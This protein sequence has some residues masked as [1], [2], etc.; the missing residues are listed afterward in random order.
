V[1]PEDSF[2][3]VPPKPD[4]SKNVALKDLQDAP[5]GTEY[6]IV[7]EHGEILEY[8]KVGNTQG[9]YWA[10]N[11]ATA[12]SDDDWIPSEKLTVSEANANGGWMSEIVKKPKSLDEKKADKDI[13]SAEDMLESDLLGDLNDMKKDSADQSFKVGNVDVTPSD[14]DAAL[15]AIA[16]AKKG[17]NTKAVLKAADNPLGELDDWTA[18]A[19]AAKPGYAPKPGFIK[20]LQDLQK[21]APAKSEK[22]SDSGW[23]KAGE[24]KSV[25]LDVKKPLDPK[26]GVPAV[27][28]SSYVKPKTASGYAEGAYEVEGAF[29]KYKIQVYKDGSSTWVAT[30]GL[31]FH[32]NSGET[33]T[34]LDEH[35]QNGKLQTAFGT[36]EPSEYV[37]AQPA[38]SGNVVVPKSLMDLHSKVYA[39]A[40]DSGDLEA[41]D[42]V[43]DIL[44]DVSKGHL[45]ADAAEAKF[46]ALLEKD[47]Q[48]QVEKPIEVKGVTFSPEA[49]L[50]LKQG[51]ENG[52]DIFDPAIWE[53]SGVD[54][55]VELLETDDFNLQTVYDDLIEQLAAHEKAKQ[56][57]IPQSN[58]PAPP[59][60][61]MKDF[62][63]TPPG[64]Y[65]SNADLVN[66]MKVMAADAGHG[67]AAAQYRGKM[68][69]Q[70]KASWI[71]HWY[72][73][74]LD[75]AYAIE[76][77]AAKLSGK[78]GHMF[79]DKH[80][81][82]PQ[83]FKGKIQYA[84]AVP[85]EIPAGQEI[86][87]DSIPSQ[88]DLKQTSAWNLS[89]E[90]VDAY[91]VAA[92]MQYAHGL[93]EYDKRGWVMNHALGLK[94]QVDMA[95]MKAKKN[96]ASG[97]Y[98]SQPIVPPKPAL[99]AGTP[100]PGNFPELNAKLNH[101]VQMSPEQLNEYLSQVVGHLNVKAVLFQDEKTK[102]ALVQLHWLTTAPEGKDNFLSKSEATQKW[103]ALLKTLTINVAQYQSDAGDNPLGLPDFGDKIKDFKK[104]KSQKKLAGYGEKFFVEDEYGEKFLFKVAKEEFR[105]YTEDAAHQAASLF[106][107]TPAHSQVTKV[108]GQLGQIQSLIDHTAEIRDIKPKDLTDAQLADMLRE[109]VLDW[110]LDND[111]GHDQNFLVTPTGRVVGIDKGRAWVH[112]G[113]NKLDRHHLSGNAHLYYTDIYNAIASG[114]I[115]PERVTKAYQ[116]AMQR[117]RLMSRADDEKY[118][119]I[120]EYAFDK[121]PGYGTTTAANKAEL[122]DQVIARKNNLEQDF[123]EFW[124]KLFKDAGIVK[125]PPSKTIGE[126]VHV[127]FTPELMEQVAKAGQ[128]GHATFFAGKDLED[129]HVLVWEENKNGGKQ[130]NGQMQLTGQADAKLLSW[131]KTH[132][133]GSG[134][135]PMAGPVGDAVLAPA[136]GSPS[137]AELHEFVLHGIK[138]ISTHSMDGAYNESKIKN[139]E[140]AQGQIEVALQQHA[141]KPDQGE[142]WFPGKPKKAAAYVEMLENYKKSIDAALLAKESSSKPMKFQR[143][144]YTPEA[145]N[146]PDIPAIK[147]PDVPF[148]V[149][150]RDSQYKVSTVDEDTGQL[151]ATDQVHK[152]NSY[153]QFGKEYHVQ[154][155][156]GTEFSYRPWNKSNYQN[157]KTQQGQ[158]KFTVPETHSNQ[159]EALDQ[160]KYHLQSSGVS[161][162]EPAEE[163]LELTY[164]RHL[165]GIMNGRMD[166]NDGPQ[167][168]VQ[169]VVGDLGLLNGS[170]DR[171]AEI[172]GWRKAWAEHSGQS[173]V[174]SWVESKSFLPQFGRVSI[175][176]HENVHGRPYWN[177]F[178]VDY[179]AL[180]ENDL[181]MINIS[182]NGAYQLDG[183]NDSRTA[184]VAKSGALMS[185]DERIHTLGQY[186]GG[187]SSDA[188]TKKGSANYVFLRQNKSHAGV[189]I[190][191]DPKL[192]ARTSTYSLNSD[193]CGDVDLRS[194]MSP[195]DLKKASKFSAE[196]NE[197][198][199]KYGISILDDV[200]LM[201]FTSPEER[202]KI[203]QHYHD[204]GIFTLHGVPIEQVFVLK[205]SRAAGMAAA[206]ERVKNG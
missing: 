114:Q 158:L 98:N 171:D 189:N 23:L 97:Y 162:D 181:L 163:D 70:Q 200:Q 170:L 8:K 102:Q 184:Q 29:Q 43:D 11:G 14:I 160:I 10:P 31:D 167:A 150:L 119:K 194:T 79:A 128:H 183:M 201:V 107:F 173:K 4:A 117:A 103:D 188:D 93:T 164:W 15:E 76:D 147:M 115:E 13:P 133:D 48:E 99:P 127:G 52:A 186:V 193:N 41:A 89:T 21:K 132:A 80:P 17:Q 88:E 101:A 203:I 151:T 7:T 27:T 185:T 63:P 156:D 157:E 71:Q 105:P 139:L 50:K 56:I 125:P 95:S 100:V 129:G 134:G 154:F 120:L 72:N 28:P 92:G 51:A 86:I 57:Q 141:S 96:V 77:Y 75:K 190:Y 155:D 205:S 60:E 78:T 20:M 61:G 64:S 182:G 179:K 24:A 174:D 42:D 84:A 108:D 153:L 138:T 121:R 65:S 83:N 169:K 3:A 85:G 6:E 202:L 143:Y 159:I 38:P 195:F 39:Q 191:L 49:V 30:N 104:A 45:T 32:Y 198:M 110:A 44:A 204:L 206:K 46:V 87:G 66:A 34:L 124:T 59:I 81:G 199:V 196:R 140:I 26:M 118:R 55:P 19:K 47:K 178:D 9:G 94:I 166:R 18:V 144:S 5:N 161:M 187:A 145:E 33:K 146:D 74:D 197:M 106:G 130:L 137:E 37:D 109:H 62:Y 16:N 69:K 122:I 53:E 36:P 22:K 112:F 12:S 54:V 40:L 136:G 82:S 113:R 192:A 116:L 176:D 142:K 58:L 172:E 165:Y 126:H 68:S 149:T 177:R 35:N 91:M 111:D 135:T 131:L 90:V 152:G 175:H 1:A 25:T 168:K 67:K 123:D 148:K 73:G 2:D 180:G